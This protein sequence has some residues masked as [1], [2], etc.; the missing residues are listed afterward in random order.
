MV[1]FHR[2]TFG[3]QLSAWCNRGDVL[4]GHQLSCWGV[5]NPGTRHMAPLHRLTETLV[6]FLLATSLWAKVVTIS[7]SHNQM[8]QLI[9]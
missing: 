3:D 4:V 7:E 1:K 2:V 9:T 8:V 6:S 5:W